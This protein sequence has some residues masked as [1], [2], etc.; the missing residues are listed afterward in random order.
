MAVSVERFNDPRY[1]R[2]RYR[3]RYSER[4][5]WLIDGYTRGSF[6]TKRH[7]QNVADIEN[8]V[9]TPVVLTEGANK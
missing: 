6:K 4:Q 9:K 1:S 7:A 3:L 8:A 5:T 2:P